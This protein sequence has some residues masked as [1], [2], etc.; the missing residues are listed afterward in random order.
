MKLK[1]SQAG[2]YTRV[3]RLLGTAL[4]A[5]SMQVTITGW[6]IPR[7]TEPQDKASADEELRTSDNHRRL[8]STVLLQGSRRRP[9]RKR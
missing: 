5:E 7:L 8:L 6:L 9:A 1:L 3:T 2:V 4:F